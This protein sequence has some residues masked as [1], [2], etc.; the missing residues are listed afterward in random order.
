MSVDERLTTHEP[1]GFA[2]QFAV[3]EKRRRLRRIAGGLG[4]YGTFGIAAFV[5]E[6]LAGTIS[7]LEAIHLIAAANAGI[8]ALFLWRDSRSAQLLTEVDTT[9][10]PQPSWG[11][12]IMSSMALI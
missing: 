5:G 10:V 2:A 11:L 12:R 7:T 6:A 4:L 8:G 3:A 9:E 1:E